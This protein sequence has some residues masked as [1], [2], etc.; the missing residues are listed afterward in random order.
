MQPKTMR[1]RPRLEERPQISAQQADLNPFM[2]AAADVQRRACRD[3]V[4]AGPRNDD[5][6]LCVA[7]RGNPDKGPVAIL[8]YCGDG[9]YGHS[10]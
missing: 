5:G 3:N 4:A 7:R 8:P 10:R 6:V 9:D 1:G 2:A